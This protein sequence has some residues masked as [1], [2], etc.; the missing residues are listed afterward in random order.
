MPTAEL[1]G[2]VLPVT[3]VVPVF[4]TAFGWPL[5]VAG[6]GKTFWLLPFAATGAVLVGVVFVAVDDPPEVLE[7]PLPGLFPPLLPLPDG[8]GPFPLSSLSLS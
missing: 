6:A 8:L 2:V 5:L 3:G 7:A 1:T 4:E